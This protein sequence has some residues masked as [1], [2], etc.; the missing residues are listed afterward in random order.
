MSEQDK[1]ATGAAVGKDGV[2]LQGGSDWGCA[3]VV[4]AICMATVAYHYGMAVVAHR[5]VNT[6]YPDA[7]CVEVSK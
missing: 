7:G 6:V 1:K 4:V 3:A 5:R 2:H